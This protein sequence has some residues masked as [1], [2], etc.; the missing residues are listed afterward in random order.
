MSRTTTEG[1]QECAQR[2]QKAVAAMKFPG[3]PASFGI[4]ISIGLTV[5]QPR[6]SIDQIIARADGALY[7][8]KAAGRNRVIAVNQ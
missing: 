5:Y 1:A 6:E 8:A 7:S 3:F 2:I 4:T